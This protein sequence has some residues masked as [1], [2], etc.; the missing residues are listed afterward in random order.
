[1]IIHINMNIVGVTV[2]IIND[3]VI[4][5]VLLVCVLQLVRLIMLVI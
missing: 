1:M 4:I 2:G 5:I 3:R